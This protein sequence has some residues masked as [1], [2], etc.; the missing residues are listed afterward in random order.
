[1]EDNTASI[2]QPTQDDPASADDSSELWPRLFALYDREQSGYAH[3]D[4]VIAA[5][6]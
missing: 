6:R 5:M 4:D 1:M 2:E 3:A